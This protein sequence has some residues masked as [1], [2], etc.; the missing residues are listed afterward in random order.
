MKAKVFYLLLYLIALKTLLLSPLET[1]NWSNMPQGK[2]LL[3]L[4]IVLYGIF[5]LF[6]IVF[7]ECLSS[8]GQDRDIRQFNQCAG[9][10][11]LLGGT[12]LCVCVLGHEFFLKEN[13]WFYKLRNN[14]I[15]NKAHLFMK[16]N[17]V[18]FLNKKE[19]TV[20]NT[21]IRENKLKKIHLFM[22]M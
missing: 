4:Q 9:V 10:K 16:S 12:C 19:I 18:F 11:N 17:Q 15:R 14:A 8:C 3:R 20:I 6:L 7:H 5:K 1:T 2:F 22:K 13:I 21:C